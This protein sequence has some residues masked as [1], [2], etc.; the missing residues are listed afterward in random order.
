AAAATPPRPELDPD[1]EEQRRAAAAGRLPISLVDDLVLMRPQAVKG[2]LQA[3][4][5]AAEQA[6]A[7]VVAAA[8][9]KAK[10]AAGGEAEVP[11]ED[12]DAEDLDEDEMDEVAAGGAEEGTRR[13]GEETFVRRMR[14]LEHPQEPAPM[15]L[16]PPP[17][18]PLPVAS[19]VATS[20]G[21]T[22][23]Q[24][25]AAPTAATSPPA[26]VT[27]VQAPVAAQPADA[28][29]FQSAVGR[30]QYDDP[31]AIIPRELTEA[32]SQALATSLRLQRERDS[33]FWDPE[34]GD[35]FADDYMADELA[36]VSEREPLMLGLAPE[37]LAYG[38]FV[39]DWEEDIIWEGA[40]SAVGGGVSSGGGGGG[41]GTDAATTRIGLCPESPLPAPPAPSG[42]G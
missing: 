6:A 16:L 41:N 3:E 36:L 40:G 23:A 37:A 29:A 10:A 8:K 21:P 38:V 1:L 9:A 39:E 30:E 7:A 35:A 33:A 4:L 31:Y 25:Q 11:E 14:G 42:C 32:L 2:G 24:A 26:V 34:P 22:P 20:P 28:T 18:P 15:L 17:L 13:E 12:E 5:E 19:P 27:S